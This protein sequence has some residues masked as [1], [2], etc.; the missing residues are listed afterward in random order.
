MYPDK[1]ISFYI[2]TKRVAMSL[3]PLGMR[4]SFYVL[5]RRK[6]SGFM[7]KFS[8]L[9][10]KGLLCIVVISL[11]VFGA[12]SVRQMNDMK[13]ISKKNHDTILQLKD[14]NDKNAKKIDEMNERINNQA[15]RMVEIQ[16]EWDDGKDAVKALKN[17]GIQKETDIGAHT[18]I[19]VS[20]MNKIIDY[21]DKHIKEGTPFKGR[22]DVFIKASKKTG[23]NPIYLFAHAACESSYGNSYLAKTRGNYFGINAVDSNPDR[24]SHMGDDIEDGIISGAV[25][26]KENYYDN[27][28]TTLES[29]RQAGYASDPNWAINISSVANTAISVL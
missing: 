9:L 7:S 12:Y 25:W 13:D 3:I 4:E 20:D 16:K 18:N 15:D 11:F 29:M 24:A 21:Y 23:L 19:T 22:G 8:A 10:Y 6:V 5:F 1:G 27:G 17:Y 26:I 2:K 28:Y 14:E